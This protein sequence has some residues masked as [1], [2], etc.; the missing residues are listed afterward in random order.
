MRIEV[1]TE[2]D[3]VVIW[4]DW[5]TETLVVLLGAGRIFGL[6]HASGTHYLASLSIVVA[7]SPV[8]VR[9]TDGVMGAEALLEDTLCR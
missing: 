9:T 8:V 6:G 1:S 4:Q 5:H 7:G 3:R 2:H